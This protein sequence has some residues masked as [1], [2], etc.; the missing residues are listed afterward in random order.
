MADTCVSRVPVFAGLSAHDQRQVAGLA[1]PTH[2]KARE[3]AHS[4]DDHLPQLMVL[5]TGRVKI[6]RLS[7]DGS[8]QIVRVLGPG[9]FTGETSV[10]TGQRPDDYATALDDSQLCVFRHDD[11]KAL[12]RQHPEIGLRMLATVSE[13]LSDTEHR[14]N[15][16]TSRDVENRLADYLLGLPSTWRGR[17]ATVSLPL[18]KK[19]VASLLDTSP[20]SLSRALSTLA[21]QGLI[22]I[23]AGRSVSITQPDLL[24]RLVDES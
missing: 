16:L 12:I 6:F 8:E 4:A 20:E 1:H 2:L 18:A 14:L 24:Q 23:G 19:D 5:H 10:F 9:E 11:L 15:L 21:R 3:S 22:V 13:R 7:A 17:V